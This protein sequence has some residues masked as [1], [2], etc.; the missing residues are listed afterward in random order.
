MSA[1]ARPRCQRAARRREAAFE[2]DDYEQ[3]K[4]ELE[5][6]VEQ[7]KTLHADELTLK[8]KELIDWAKD[9]K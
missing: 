4:A 6:F 2:L 7:T 3:A 9:L 5:K 8:G 1:A